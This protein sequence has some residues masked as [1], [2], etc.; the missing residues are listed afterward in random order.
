MAKIVVAG[1][2]MNGLTAALLLAKDGHS[3]TVVERDP[4]EPPGSD[5]AWDTWERRGVNQFRMLHFLQPR[6]REIVE[7]ELPELAEAFERAGALRFNPL[8][9]IP[10]EMIGGVRA[11]RRRHAPRSPPADRS[12]RRQPRPVVDATPG[13]TVRR[14]VA[15]T[16]SGH[17]H[18]DGRRR[19]PHNRPRDRLR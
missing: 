14:G 15:I 16:G 13:I 7:A 5:E 8:E 1:A 18:T 3:V 11:R 10:P 17:G 9:L 19:A 2:G 6:W 12:P 4:A